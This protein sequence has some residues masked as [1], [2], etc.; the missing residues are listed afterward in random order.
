[1]DGV[2]WFEC[3][4][5]GKV[6]ENGLVLSRVE[7]KLTLG[8]ERRGNFRVEGFWFYSYVENNFEDFYGGSIVNYYDEKMIKN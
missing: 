5:S 7:V 3:L 2:G 1:L 6:N 8:E 4:K